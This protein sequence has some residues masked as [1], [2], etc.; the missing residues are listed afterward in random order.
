MSLT[1]AIAKNTTIQIAGKAISTLLGLLAVA[2]MTRSLGPEKFGWY[3][4]ATGFLQFVG[5][6]SD[7]G[8]TVLTAKMLSEPD[9]DKT[10]LLNNLFTLRL[11]SAAFF[12]LLA[13]L[14][15]LFFPYPIQVKIGVA[16]TTLSFFCIALNNIFIG[17]Y[18]ANLRMGTQMTGE[19]IGRVV[20]VGGLLLSSFYGNG[21]I[22]T[23]SIITLASIAYTAFLW[24]RGPAVRFEIDRPISK[25]IFKKI[26][27][28][29]LSVI[30]NAFY[31]LGD[32]VILPL[33]VNQTQVGI[34]G[35]AYRIIDIITQVA[36]MTMGIM[37]PLA[38]FAWSR[39]LKNDFKNKLQTSFDLVLLILMPMLVGIYILAG[40]IMKIVAG[41]GF[42][43]SEQILKFL[44]FTIL[45][46]SIGNIF[47]YIILAMNK[48]RQAIVVYLS[49][50]ILST[51]GYFYFI[52][53][54]GMYGAAGVAIFSEIYAGIGLLLIS[55]YYAS[56]WP[57]L[58]N[59]I[60]ISIAS[61]GMGA[62][63]FYLQPLNII[64][65]IFVGMATYSIFIIALRTV[66]K[67]TLMEI[68]PLK[69]PS[70]PSGL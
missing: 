3:V 19:I 38:T 11:L 59:F 43:G 27:P 47:G 35:A 1:R 68:M 24:A 15:F 49:D 14:V 57:R 60:K 42:E 53:K 70:D 17:Y 26:W 48:Q 63:I 41:N 50:A 18:Q 34:Y 21:Y 10:K 36:A 67:R 9:F 69:E 39:N 64:T 12:H 32:R 51:I 54:Y 6:F 7:F 65:S 61:I 46:I 52:P 8:F 5:I 25:E 66:S 40:P 45:G 30:F 4:T 33:F 23:M 28:M 44:S 31:L 20:L 37:T 13:P 56:Y 29:G 62:I 55:S 58:K 2:I 16:I 22:Y